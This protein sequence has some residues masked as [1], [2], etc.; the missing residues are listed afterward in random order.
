MHT[1]LHNVLNM[2]TV[3]PY[4]LDCIHRFTKYS[5][6]IQSTPTQGISQPLTVAMTQ[7]VVN[8]FLIY[9]ACS[10][11]TLQYLYSPFQNMPEWS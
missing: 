8:Q 7:I 6:C 3:Y 4:T 1:T 5:P 2:Y 10:W 11:S 9:D